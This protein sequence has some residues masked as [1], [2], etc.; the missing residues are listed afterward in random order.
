MRKL[1]LILLALF[2]FNQ[3]IAQRKCGTSEALQ[4]MIKDNPKLAAVVSSYNN[5]MLKGQ[6]KP[7]TEAQPQAVTIPVVVHIVLDNPDI[8]SDAQ[9]Q[10][11]IDV[12]NKDYTATN[13]DVMLTPAVWQSLIGNS[14]IN[15]CLAQRTP[16]GEPSNGIVRVKTAPG[17]SFQIYN[18]AP[19]V[20]Y[21]TTGGSDAWDSKRYL[22]IWV[23]RLAGNYLGVAAPSTYGYPAD[24]LGVVIMYNA[25]GTIGQELSGIYNKGRTATHEIGHFFGLKHIWGDDNGDCSDDDG[26]ADTPLQGTNSFGCPTFP[27]TDLCSP[28]PP[29]I[30]FMNYMDYTD[31][32]CMHLFTAGQVVRMRYVLEN[33]VQPLMNSNG[34]TP[35][36]VFPNDAAIRQLPF[37]AGKIC[38]KNIMPS[39]VLRNKGSQPLTSVK[40]N[41]QVGSGPLVAYQWTGNLASFTETTLTLPSS[42][43]DIGSY[44]IKA[45]TQL[46]NGQPDGDPSNDTARNRFN[47]DAEASL[48]F[49]EGFENDSFPPPGWAIRN[50]DQSFTWERARDV[51]S[52]S[53]ASALM[54]NLGYNT[55]YQQDDL[56][57]PVLDPAGSD[58]V[59]LFFDVA[60]AVFT[61]PNTIGNMWDTL[62]VLVSTDCMNTSTMLYQ[63]WGP[64]LITHP[65]ALQT[66][67]VPAANEWRRD[68]VD[69]TAAVHKGK[70]QVIFRNI[71]N[72]ENNIYIDNINIVTKEVNEDLR[73]QGVLV[74]PNPSSG[75]V[76]VTFY[77]VPEDLL[78]VSI[79]NAA[80]QFITS[81]PKSAINNANRMTFNLVNEPNGVYFVK[82]IYRNRA[83]TIKLM[84]VR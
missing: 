60:A 37:P 1:I 15:F 79:Y 62:Q 16:D 21:S 71:S 3:L 70:F 76:W 17:R 42:K 13:S 47:Y 65:T 41:Y 74:N 75:L 72:S 43:V 56:L 66:E 67:F 51:G 18:G 83:N 48:P 84:K 73:R 64:N 8:V 24:Q 22:N 12:L 26:I 68:S 59:F 32:A 58:S 29:G 31:D 23:T 14:N 80:G 33:V 46:P 30:M 7:R 11:Q 57:T 28:T 10:S 69:L 55:N 35:P 20:K 45:Y 44:N 6:L 36:V 78:Q 40:I 77:Q 49:F 9:V 81:L 4:Q 53:K 38:D 34:C 82:L 50:P 52:N 39:V 54:R 63:K 61:N 2:C 25:F 27:K 5:A 19:D